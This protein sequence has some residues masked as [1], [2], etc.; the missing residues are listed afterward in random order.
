MTRRA[1][2]ALCSPRDDTG[3]AAAVSSATE[4]T[5]HAEAAYNRALIMF[6]RLS[7]LIVIDWSQDDSAQYNDRYEVD[8]HM[9]RVS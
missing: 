3:T 4:E 9:R 6:V 5:T 7:P 8:I 1:I 2:L